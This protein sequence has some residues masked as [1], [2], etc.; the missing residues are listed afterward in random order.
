MRHAPSSSI[1]EVVPNTN[2]PNADLN[3]ELK[4][5]GALGLAE[6]RPGGFCGWAP[7]DL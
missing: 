4:K 1:I 5:L 2:S 7:V 3:E 6:R